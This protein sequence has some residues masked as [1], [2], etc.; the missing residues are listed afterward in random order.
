[1]AYDEALADRA[2]SAIGKRPDVSEKKMFGGV[3]F[4]L[5]EKM[6]VGIVKEELLVR[7]GPERFEEAL[8]RPHVRP[9]D[10]TGRPMVGFVYVAAPGCRTVKQVAAWAER[11]EKFVATVEKKPKRAKKPSDAKAAVKAKATPTRRS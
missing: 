9:M 6:F 2:R 8:A 10:F 4:L 5:D 7:V 11:A 3:A 1:M